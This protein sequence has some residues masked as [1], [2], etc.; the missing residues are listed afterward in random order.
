ML[1]GSLPI[2]LVWVMAQNGQADLPRRSMAQRASSGS[3][4]RSIS[5]HNATN[6]GTIGDLCICGVERKTGPVRAGQTREL[7]VGFGW[8]GRHWSIFKSNGASVGK[9][10]VLDG[11]WASAESPEG[12]HDH[13]ARSPHALRLGWAI[14]AHSSGDHAGLG[15]LLRTTSHPHR[16]FRPKSATP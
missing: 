4:L 7:P 8:P 1:R 6:K 2:S 12:V 14:A 10:P 15:S 5:L 11:P 9:G 13:C 16:D 3:L